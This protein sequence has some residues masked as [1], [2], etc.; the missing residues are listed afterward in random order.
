VKVPIVW[1]AEA[2]A[3]LPEARAWYDNIGPALGERFAKSIDETIEAISEN[4][5]QLQ[6]LYRGCRRAGVKRFP[7]GIF[8]EVQE[9]RIVAIAC[10]HGRR[11]P[12]H[13]QTR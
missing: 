6:V 7:Y 12:K 3:D 2:D 9:Y 5:R 4:P 13:W 10:F 8:F 11:N 1:T